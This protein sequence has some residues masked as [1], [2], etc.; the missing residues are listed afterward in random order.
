MTCAL[1]GRYI[2]LAN[3]PGSNRWTAEVLVLAIGAAQLQPPR[4]LMD[5]MV[6]LCAECFAEIEIAM[7]KRPSTVRSIVTL[8][9]AAPTRRGA[10]QALSLRR[11]AALRPPWWRRLGAVLGLVRCR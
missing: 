9:R 5:G 2:L 7:A 6:D 1:C 4:K 3:A 8:T 10:A 11:E